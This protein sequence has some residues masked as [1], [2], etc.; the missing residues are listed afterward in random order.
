MIPS[1]SLVE[2]LDS[3]A[4][5]LG[6]HREETVCQSRTLAV[7]R[8]ILLPQLVAGKIWVRDTEALVGAVT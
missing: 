1:T 2:A 7:L 4:L 6:Y 5:L 8:D 3:F